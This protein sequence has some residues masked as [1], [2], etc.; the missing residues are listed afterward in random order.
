MSYLYVNEQGAGISFEG[1]R[2]IVKYKNDMVKSVPAE[3]M[4]QISVF[5]AVQLTT[6]CMQECLKRGVDVIF[7]S[8][9]GAYFGRL[10]STGHVNVERQRA[11]AALHSDEEFKLGLAR[12][13][14]DAK[15]KNQLVIIRR[16]ERNAH[17]PVDI[18]NAETNMKYM[19]GKIRTAETIEQVMG[20]EGTAAK[21]YFKMLGELV[22]EEFKFSGRSRRPPKDPFNSMLS[23]G[24]SILMN[25][26]YGKIEAK[27]LNPYFGF[28]HKDREKHPTLASDLMEEW[29]A[30]LVDAV[31]MSMVNGHEVHKDGFY[32]EEGEAGVFLDKKTFSDF[33][34]KLEKKFRTDSRYLSYTDYSVS[35]R[36]AIDLQVSQL[37]KAIE[38]KNP[39][40]YMPVIIR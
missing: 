17:H 34:N 1:N 19:L 30:P 3:L 36:R 2:F 18:H 39:D 14:I 6:Q 4:E 5:G 9:N 23:L 16:Y 27:G 32:S 37:V 13:I 31:V 12:K 8:K 40:E 20:Y 11:Q 29:R 21:I 22:D 28:M 26:I 7:Y 24:Y 10:I 33:V 38:T 15:V 35:F 25:E